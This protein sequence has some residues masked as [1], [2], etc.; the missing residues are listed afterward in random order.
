MALTNTQESFAAWLASPDGARS[1]ST[2]E[3]WAAAHE[4]TTRTLRRWKGVPEFADRLAVLRTA[5]AVQGSQAEGKDE[6]DY[7]EVKTQLIGA[8]KSGNAKALELYFRT[9][10]KPFVEEEIATR[11]ADLAGLDLDDLVTRALLALG[12]DLVAGALRRQGW[13]V[14]AP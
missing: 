9:Y 14:E 11:N 1:P 3:E 2:E 7:Q 12:P 10:G 13:R 4:V 5:N 8:A 6:V